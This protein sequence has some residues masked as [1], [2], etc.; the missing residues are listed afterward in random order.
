MEAL[1]RYLDVEDYKRAS[2]GLSLTLS[3]RSPGM[4]GCFLL[5]KLHRPIAKCVVQD[6]VSPDDGE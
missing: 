2:G 5:N 6:S 1:C 3:V 4:R